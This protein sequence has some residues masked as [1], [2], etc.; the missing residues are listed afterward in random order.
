[1]NDL[2]TIVPITGTGT[3]IAIMS[4]DANTGNTE[5]TITVSGE[6]KDGSSSDSI[7]FTQKANDVIYYTTS[8]GTPLRGIDNSTFGANIISNTYQNG[9]GVIVFESNP[10]IV[11]QFYDY[12]GLTSIEL[13]NT[14]INIDGQS[15]CDFTGLTSICL[16]KSVNYIGALA[17]DGCVNLSEVKIK[18][19]FCVVKTN[20]TRCTSLPRDEYGGVYTSF[21]EE[22][23]PCLVSYP[24]ITGYTIY[25]KT[26]FICSYAAYQ[27]YVSNVIIPDSVYSIEA[28][29]FSRCG[30]SQNP[31]N[32]V[33]GNGVKY[34]YNRAFE[35]SKITSLT[36]GNNIIYIGD[37][38]F[39]ECGS[40][41]YKMLDFPDSLEYIGKYAFYKFDYFHNKVII[42]NNVKTIGEYAF[43][44]G[45]IKI[46]IG[47]S[48]TSISSNAFHSTS[49]NY[50]T[51][52]LFYN[53]TVEEWNRV[54]RG[55]SWS[56]SR[57]TT[58]RCTNGIGSK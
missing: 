2:F 21:N 6:T 45:F 31:L 26:R 27:K 50:D 5:R 43:H 13:P 14:I 25:N 28:Y 10:T 54:T 24:N 33:I 48:V 20:F 29:A 22:D 11:N 39:N 42:P 1:M 12:D 32:V 34:I 9:Q 37:Y 23:N 55:E 36:L 30:N 17:F 44:T 53:G 51:S 16:P 41:L 49:G 8:G 18:N 19:K 46:Y 35:Y 38:A 56:T 40:N 47:H 58:V 57:E 15:F 4:I 7:T 3:T 52:D